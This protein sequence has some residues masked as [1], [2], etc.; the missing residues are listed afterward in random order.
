MKWGVLGSGAREHA[1]A[2]KLAAAYGAKQVYFLPGNV[3]YANSVAVEPSALV[4]KCQELALDVVVVGSEAL[5]AARVCDRLVPLGIKVFGPPQRSVILESSKIWAKGFMQRQGIPT[6]RYAVVSSP[7]DLAAQVARFGEDVVIKMDGLKAGKGV[8]VCGGSA[9][10]AQT[11]AMLRG[12]SAWEDL[13]IEERLVG[14]ELSVIAMIDHAG[15]LL[16]PV[17]QDY[18]RLLDG[19]RGPNTGGMGAYSPVPFY[20]PA[21]AQRIQTEIVEPTLAGLAQEDLSYQGFLYFGIMVTPAGPQLLEYNV[22]LGDPEAQVILPRIQGDFGRLI[23]ACLANQI[24]GQTCEVD[25]RAFVDVVFAGQG[26]PDH[27]SREELIAGLETVDRETLIFHAGTKQRDGQYYAAGGRVF[28]VVASAAT[29]PQ[30][31]ERTYAQC[32]RIRFEGAQYRRD[33]ASVSSPFG[34]EC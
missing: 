31:R 1:I 6:A 9:E 15:F 22:R 13:V 11:L 3:G 17:A 5:L 34:S 19:D 20:T 8:F 30:A 33:I 23:L 29:L 18:K 16:L 10:V 26:Y 28:N 12:Q 2:W 32:E 25:P 4:R 24:A 21:L 7:R 27:A 14:V